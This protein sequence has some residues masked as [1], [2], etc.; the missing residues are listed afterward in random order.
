MLDEAL[1][2][3]AGQRV[4]PCLM[5][6]RSA[7]AEYIVTETYGLVGGNAAA[8]FRNRHEISG[9]ELNYVRPSCVG[10]GDPVHG[11]WAMSRGARTGG[12][13]VT[14]IETGMPRSGDEEVRLQSISGDTSH[15]SAK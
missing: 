4:F 10:N 9:V 3:I 6:R 11:S 7:P 14:V 2:T 1:C 8:P 13:I 12:G 15:E 5:G